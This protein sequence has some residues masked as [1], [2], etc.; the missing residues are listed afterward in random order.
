MAQVTVSKE[1]IQGAKFWTLTAKLDLAYRLIQ[2]RLS[3]KFVSPNC[4]QIGH[5]RVGLLHI[6]V[7]KMES[8][9]HRKRIDL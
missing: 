8:R 4:F 9:H 5:A 2:I 1:Y 6:P 3:L 7:L